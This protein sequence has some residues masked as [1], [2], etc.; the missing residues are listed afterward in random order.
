M[1]EKFRRSYFCI[2]YF[3]LQQNKTALGVAARGDMIIIVDMIIKAERYFRWKSNYQMVGVQI[4]NLV[5]TKH[6]INAT[7]CCK[8]VGRTFSSHQMSHVA[9]TSATL[10]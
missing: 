9:I 7:V 2:F 1:L 5:K 6:E 10:H 4:Y 3:P 8:R